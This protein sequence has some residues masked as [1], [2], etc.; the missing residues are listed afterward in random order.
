MK[1]D[2]NKVYSAPSADQVKIGSKGY[3]SD[4]LKYLKDAVEQEQGEKYGEIAEIKDES[5]ESRFKM[6]DD[7]CYGLFYPV[8]DPKKTEYRPYNDVSEMIDHFC[9]HFN[10]VSST[11]SLPHIWVKGKPESKYKDE[12]AQAVGFYEN[13]VSIGLPCNAKDKFTLYTLYELFDHFTYLDGT[14]CGIKE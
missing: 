6:K 7:Y 13:N 4:V 8:E 3:F 10:L 2:L 9:S 1:F 14:P 12:I 11:C 5:Y